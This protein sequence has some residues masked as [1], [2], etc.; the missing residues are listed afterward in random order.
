MC[1]CVYVYLCICVYVY[2]WQYAF[3]ARHGLYVK[4][5]YHRKVTEF[6]LFCISDPGWGRDPR[7]S[8]KATEQ[9]SGKLPEQGHIFLGR[10]ISIRSWAER[11]PKG[12]SHRPQV[13]PQAT[14]PEPQP[15][16]RPP[17]TASSTSKLSLKSERF[18]STGANILSKS[19]VFLE[20][21]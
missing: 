20:R 17:A 3:Y 19:V 11:L 13:L 9:N 4:R 12:H 15:S 21:G 1:I 5:L 2:M 10:T 6:T 8:L 18:V 7:W 14:Q 16:A